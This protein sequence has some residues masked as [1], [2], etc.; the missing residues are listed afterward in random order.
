VLAL[1][2]SPSRVLATV[3]AVD[4]A[5]CR[6]RRTWCSC[7]AFPRLRVKGLLASEGDNV[8]IEESTVQEKDSR[9]A[10]V[11]VEA[12][13]LVLAEEATEATLLTVERRES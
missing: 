9:L 10:V 6:C 4:T 2:S 1:S 12:V 5:R 3:L 13:V 8:P 7:F 11:L